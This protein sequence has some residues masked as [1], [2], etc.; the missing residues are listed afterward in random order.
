[1][2]QLIKNGCLLAVLTVLSVGV[3]GADVT[4]TGK[5]DSNW[6]SSGNWS[7]GRVPGTKPGDRVL[8]SG[9]TV[10]PVVAT[11]VEASNPCSLH[12]SDDALLEVTRSGLLCDAVVLGAENGAGGGHLLLRGRGEAVMVVKGDLIAGKT[13]AAASD[14]S[15]QLRTGTLQVDGGLYLGK[16]S[17]SVL[18]NAPAIVA[19][20]LAVSSSGTLRFDFNTKPVQTIRVANKL[21]LKKGAK[22]EIDLSHYTMGGNQ[23]ELITF[24]SVSG[25]FDPKN[26]SIKGLGGGIITMDEDSLNLT[27]IDDVAKRSSTLWF[28]ATGGTGEEPLDLQIN[29]GRRIRNLSSPDLSYSS[30]TDGD[31]MV[32]A[33]KWSGSDFDGDGANDTVSFDLRVAGFAGSVYSYDA[34]SEAASMTALGKPAAVRGNKAGWGVGKDL[35]LDAGE[36]LRFSVENLKLSTPGVGDIGHFVGMQMTETD[37]GK[38]HVLM[39]GEGENLNAW[40]RSNNLGIGFKPEYPLLVT[41]VASSKVGVNQV[42]LRLF[43]SDLPDHMNSEANDYSVYPTGPQ[44][45]SDYPKVTKRLHSEFSWD[46]LPMTARVNSR[47]AL[48]ASY[49]RIMA[50][51]Y[52]KIGLGGNSFYGSK[53]IDD[54]VRKMAALLKSFNPDVLLTTYRN[55]GIHFTDFSADEKLNK[56]EWFDYTLDENGKRKYITYSGKQNAYNHDHPD[57]R[58][59]WVDTAVDLLNDPNIDGIFIDKANGGEEPLLNDSGELEAP[60]GKVQSYIDLMERAPK[61]AF[62]TGNIL[63]TNRSGGNRELLHI[64]NGTYLESWEKVNGDSL[65]TMTTADTVCASLQL[66]REARVKGFDVFTNFR[67]LKWHRTKSKDERVDK[68]VAAGREEEIREGMIQA[69]QYPLAFFLITAEPYSYFQYQTSTDPEMPEFCWNAKAHFDEFRNPLGKPLGPP[70]KDGYIY[71]RSFEHVDVWLD[72][73]NETS[74]LTWDWKP[75]A[76]SQAVQVVKDTPK[77]ITLT[78]SDPRKTDLSFTVFKYG[79]PANGTL[80]GKAPNLVYTPNPG[81]AGVDSFSFKTHN[82]MAESLLAN[83]SI[84][85][86]PSRRNGRAR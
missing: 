83:V 50:T 47:K 40:E 60:E 20:D 57:F 15:V 4:W 31:D 39:V 30:N 23:L 80:S 62:L 9:R 58:K 44:H 49:A 69:F 3:Q 22:L 75:I 36:T 2:K 5:V 81:F 19:K 68:L 32:H 86:T 56:K 24:S 35:D 51:T 53:F 13:D 29:T 70:V 6:N 16:G 52:A 66:I 59:W 11:L 61:D 82:D 42:A 18:G 26:I 76:D 8:L 45:L 25:S 46:T 34:G 33:V 84:Q 77:A 7:T 67:G 63:R 27:V 55:A 71:T 74:R 78:G 10:A 72:V 28:V 17:L 64:F 21:T 37:G 38:N 43:V 14:S 54:G 1:M 73:E 41:S 65:V 85:V 79:Q 12:L 48:P